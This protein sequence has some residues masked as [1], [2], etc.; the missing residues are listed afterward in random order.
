MDGF[1]NSYFGPL[2]RD[3]CLYFL[4]MSIFFFV[5][6][7]LGIIGIIGAL[8]SKGKKI[9]MLFLVHSIM[10]LLNAVL[11]YFVNRLLNTM[12]MNSTH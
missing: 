11:A 5:M 4:F 6:I 9:D 12:C 10:L 1:M 2:G 8:V 7:I 3:Y